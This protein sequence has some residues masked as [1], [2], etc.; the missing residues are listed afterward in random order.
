[1]RSVIF[2]LR[3]FTKF[4]TVIGIGTTIHKS[5]DVNGKYLL[6]PWI[7]YYLQTTDVRL[8]Y[9]KTY[10]NLHGAHSIIKSFNVKI[11][12]K[13]HNVAI[14]INRKEANL[15]I[16]YNPNVTS[17]QNKRHGSLLRSG[18]SFI[19]LDSLDLFVG[20]RTD[21]DSSGTEV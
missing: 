1:M 13:N 6:L 15:P 16:I 17:A 2:L 12:L 3:M 4:N 18:M 8:F 10:H 20:I 14:P 9:K 19:G 7:S 21:I 5:V 11:V